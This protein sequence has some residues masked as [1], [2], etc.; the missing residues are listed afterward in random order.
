MSPDEMERL[1][2]KIVH[3]VL[4]RI[5]QD[6]DLAP[7]LKRESNLSSDSTPKE[8]ARTCTSYREKSSAAPDS[9][10]PTEKISDKKLFTERD[11][12]NLAKSGQTTLR[13]MKTSIITPAAQDVAKLKGITITRA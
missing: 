1:V 2:D 8:W 7:L 3:A 9:P 11:I 12:L 10:S 6:P 4:Q 13:V 5:E